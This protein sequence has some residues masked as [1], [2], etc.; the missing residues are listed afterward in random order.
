MSD[1]N[2]SID[3]SQSNKKLE[4]GF[5]LDN[6]YKISRV[7]GEGGFGITYDAVN[8]H[9]GKRV[10]VKENR[11]GDPQ[12]FLQEARTLHDFEEESSVVNVLD[13]FEAEGTAYIVME[14]LDGIPLALE[15][16]QKG[17]WDTEKTVHSFIPVMKA[18]EHMHQA[19]VIHRD[20]S[21]DNLM[22]LPDGKLILMDFG[23]A[24][25]IHKQNVTMTSIYK[26]VY[27]PPE[28]RESGITLGSYTD[29][30]ALCATI[31]FCIT[32]QEPEDALSR[33]LFDEL[34]KPSEC[35][36]EIKSGSEKALLD[37]L[38]LDS[39]NR[40]QDVAELRKQ[41]ENDYPDLTEEEREIRIKNAKKRKRLIFTLCGIFAL[42]ILGLIFK[43]RV[44]ILFSTI[45]TQTIILD[46]SLMQPEDFRNNA[47]IVKKR[48]EVFSD[49]KYL[50]KEDQGH[51]LFEVPSE[52]FHGI[53]PQKAV[54]FA[55]TR[56]MVMSVIVSKDSDEEK[57]L[58]IF[59]Q[60]KD[61]SSV[62]NN[63]DGLDVF[64][65][66]EAAKRFEGALDRDGT[67]LTIVFD[68]DAAY[69]D[70]GAYTGFSN[71]DGSSLHIKSD[72]PEDKSDDHFWL[73]DELKKLHLTA[74]P[75]TAPFSVLA[76]WKVR[77]EDVNTTLFPGKNQ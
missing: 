44:N 67:E 18:L 53:D 1:R 58:G 29:V 47:D 26:S 31:Y 9:S 41:L 72:D 12:K 77:W 30:Y 54:R 38:E 14:Y 22:V 46:S 70:Y 32:G 76:E 7:I 25:E 19:G 8:I 49:N 4:E 59:S 17:K 43:F 39:A 15:I 45:D 28:Q 71:G 56:P 69:S 3:S 60:K 50:W 48:V 21:P 24:K 16:R 63:K 5:I 6:R 10:A 40:T 62:E 35:G 75:S 52:L 11:H 20:I 36:A 27:S 66:N 57:N 74:M 55:L 2:S 34:K 13:Y 33:L 64:F 23:A 37:G 61:I 65:T 68:M 42:I 51:I 73:P